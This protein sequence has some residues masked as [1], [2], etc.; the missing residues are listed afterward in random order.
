[1]I[2]ISTTAICKV[3][4]AAK[5]DLGL[6][7]RI[8]IVLCVALILHLSFFRHIEK[9]DDIRMIYLLTVLHN[10]STERNLWQ[11]PNIPGGWRFLSVSRTF[12]T[13]EK[14]KSGRELKIYYYSTPNPNLT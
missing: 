3:S 12:F 6:A 11:R 10:F 2:H 9:M 13:L 7:Q 4:K 5:A 8:A 1:M 14:E